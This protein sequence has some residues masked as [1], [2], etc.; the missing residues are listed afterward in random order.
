MPNLAYSD[1]ADAVLVANGYVRASK[2]FF[3]GINSTLTGFDQ[4]IVHFA[5]GVSTRSGIQALASR[6]FLKSY[7]QG[8]VELRRKRQTNLLGFDLPDMP[9]IG[10]F[11]AQFELPFFFFK[12]LDHQGL[13]VEVSRPILITVSPAATGRCDLLVVGTTPEIDINSQIVGGCTQCEGI[14][15]TASN[16]GVA[17]YVV[18]RN[19]PP[20]FV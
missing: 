12:R 18:C 2:G 10:A 9:E 11:S 16:S 4:K 1:P 13:H 14:V 15:K 8:F 5:K 19:Q 3:L 6:S 20:I 17:C 7:V